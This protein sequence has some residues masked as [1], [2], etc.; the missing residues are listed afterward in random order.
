[1]SS[2]THDSKVREAGLELTEST[3]YFLSLDSCF[4]PLLSNA[5]SS[6][7]VMSFVRNYFSA[8]H[9][10]LHRDPQLVTVL[11]GRGCRMFRHKWDLCVTVID[12]KA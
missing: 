1:M 9:I 11:R 10:D 5:F 8:L 2:G 6:L 12:L 4:F 3:V 7:A